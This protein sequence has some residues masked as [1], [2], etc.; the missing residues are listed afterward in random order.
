MQTTGV[1]PLI[2]AATGTITESFRKYLNNL[3]GGYDINYN[4]QRYWALRVIGHY[5]HASESTCVKVRKFIVENST[6]CTI[7][8]NRSVATTIYPR[9]TACFRCI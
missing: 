9:N 8:C 4:K 2:I 1:T 6:A 7:N 5:K 3:P